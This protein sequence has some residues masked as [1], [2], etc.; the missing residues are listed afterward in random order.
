MDLDE[1]RSRWNDPEFEQLYA[2][3]LQEPTSEI[4][5]RMKRRDARAKRWR[6]A[7]RMT[8]GAPLLVLIVLA[9][10][11]LFVTHIR[12][13]PL[14]TVAF[15]LEMTVMCA[16]QLLDRAREKCEQPRLWLAPDEFLL[17]EHRR[18]GRNIRLDQWVSAL[19]CVA[20]ICL[21]LYAA[22]FLS[23]GLRVACLAATGVAVIVLHLCDRRRVSELKRSRDAL[24]AELADQPRE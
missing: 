23:A 1:F 6:R 9:V 13:T 5:K 8:I 22:P 3:M 14:Q 19:L 18:M 16:L 10:V 21:A 17:D 15:V 2:R 7:R 12:E 4:I 24:A 11:Q 20:I